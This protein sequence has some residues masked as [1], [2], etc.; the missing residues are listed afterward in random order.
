MQ[1]KYILF[2]LAILLLAACATAEATPEAPVLDSTQQLGQAVYKL[3]CAQCHA[4]TPDTVVI[5]P[6]MAGIATRAGSQVA[7]YS[8]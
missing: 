1:L 2:P 7:G 5:G 6:S 3:R 8:A 4:L